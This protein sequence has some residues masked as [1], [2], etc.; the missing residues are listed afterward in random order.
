[1][2]NFIGDFTSAPPNR[3][4]AVEEEATFICKHNP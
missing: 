3:S 4:P 1:V 2:K